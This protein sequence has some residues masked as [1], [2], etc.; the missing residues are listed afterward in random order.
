VP[1][2]LQRVAASLGIRRSDPDEPPAA[3][4]RTPV[5]VLLGNLIFAALAGGISALLGSGPVE[6]ITFG[7][8]VLVVFVFVDLGAR[9]KRREG[10]P[11][12]AG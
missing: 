8:V 12:G 4:E 7:V 6:A 2:P 5:Q 11:P 9:R 3:D 1:T 10:P